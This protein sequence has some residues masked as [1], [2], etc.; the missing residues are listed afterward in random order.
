MST[1]EAATVVEE[2]DSKCNDRMDHDNSVGAFEVD[3]AARII[4]FLRVWGM[5]Y[6][7]P[8]F[9]KGGSSFARFQVSIWESCWKKWHETVAGACLIS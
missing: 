9:A 7:G 3:G 1:T 4:V 6:G 5:E 2:A 8:R